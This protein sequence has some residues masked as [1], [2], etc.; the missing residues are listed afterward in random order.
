MIT[1]EEYLQTL[2][3]ANLLHIKKGEQT[4]Y[5]GYLANLQHADSTICLQDIVERFQAVP[6]IKHKKWREL[7]LMQP[8]QPEQTPQ[9]SFSDLQMNLYYTIILKD[10]KK[11]R[12]EEL[13]REI[14]EHEMLHCN[15][16]PDMG[17]VEACECCDVYGCIRDF[18]QEL[19][20]LEE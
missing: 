9:Y 15:H 17:L 5:M 2:T 20:S 6:E 19:R 3:G 11:E 18:E 13:R 7:G 1:L 4:L 8:L 10:E 14:M 16:C 12:I